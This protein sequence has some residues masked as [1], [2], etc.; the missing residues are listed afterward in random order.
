MVRRVSIV[1][2]LGVVLVTCAFAQE[3]Q[4]VPEAVNGKPR[5]V[6]VSVK[7]IEFQTT[8]GV[9]TGLSAYFA[10]R[11]KYR[12][13]GRVTSGNGA[14]T[15]ADITFPTST[16]AGITVFLDRLRMSEGNVEVVLQALVNENRAFIL[17]RP[18]AMVMVGGI[19]TVKTTQRIPYEDTQVVGVL[20]VQVTQFRDT[21]VMLKVGVPDI[22]D[23]DG[24][25][26][27]NDDT[28]IFLDVNAEVKEVGQRIVVALDDQLAGGGDFSLARNAITAPEFLSRS[29][30]T[31][32]CVR[33]G[34]VLMLGGLYR[35]T[36]NKSL[37][38]LPWLTQGEDLVIGLAERLVPGEF[39]A[40]PLSATVGNRA[41][42]EGR[43]ELVFMI[44]AE[45]WRPAY[46]VA[47]EHGFWDFEDD[48]EDEKERISPTDVITDVLEGISEIPQD[49]VEG[50]TGETEEK[51][52]SSLGGSE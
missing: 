42:T 28:Y 22:I 36:K 14:I 1:G 10:R 25:W 41:T 11:N 21:G 47:D 8:K 35:N 39:L 18:K 2:F 32:V 40:S 7:V 15:S 4:P 45:V 48:E 12:A 50:I 34:Q 44:K 16:A 27:T 13:Y 43:R 6:I 30:D 9:E 19:T 33:H 5:Q 49:I 20:A 37:T 17:S 24:D 52:E 38:T 3:G 46:T 31:H 51:V 29:I 26:T 23:D